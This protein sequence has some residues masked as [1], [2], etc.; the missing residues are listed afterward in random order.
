MLH[1]LYTV[2]I[3]VAL[4]KAREKHVRDKYDNWSFFPAVINPIETNS[5]LKPM[6]CIEDIVALL[7]LCFHVHNLSL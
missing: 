3:L 5:A 2:W 1:L 6:M 7:I 4:F